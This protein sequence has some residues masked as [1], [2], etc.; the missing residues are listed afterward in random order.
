MSWWRRG[1]HLWPTSD[2]AMKIGLQLRGL[3]LATALLAIAVAWATRSAWNQLGLLEREFGT[4]HSESYH[5]AE[6]VQARM[7]ALNDVLLRLELN[8]DAAELT[9]FL[10]AGQ[11]MDSWI[12]DNKFSV[13]TRQQTGLLGQIQEALRAYLG[14]VGGVV[15]QDR[16]RKEVPGVKPLNEELDAEAKR[17]LALGE[18]LRLAEQAALAQ[19][20]THAHQSARNLKLNLG[21][22]VILIFGLGLASARL[23]YLVKIVP[24]NAKLAEARVVLE[25]REKLAALGTL[26]AGVAH[27][28]RNPL[29][30]IKIRLHSLKRVLTRESPG[31]Q[32]AAVINQEI[33]RLE[34]IVHEFLQFARPSAPKVQTIAA[35]VLFEQVNA[36]LLPQLKTAGIE[37]KI[38]SKGEVLVRADP[39]QLKQVLINL[40]QNAAESIE[41][42][43]LITLRASSG[44]VESGKI[45]V[46]ATI[47]EVEDTGKGI[48]PEVEKRLFDPFFSTK[49]VGAGLG[50]SIAAQIVEKHGGTLRYDTKLGVGTRFCIV[51][52]EITGD[53]QAGSSGKP[54]P[55]LA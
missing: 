13:S 46:P 20:M 19:L 11:E 35:G 25:R 51:L 26:A 12:K 37:L 18:Q 6:H 42:G 47:L 9:N 2:H 16:S 38:D 3:C 31:Q 7:L 54:H 17:V 40:I 32:D 30:A 27:E 50:L 1:I 53:T 5:L 52:P 48:A 49:E 34:R 44:A 41:R 15:K 36:L 14:K 8:G 4:S 28:I 43:G 33:Q 45:P 55:G 22:S 39:Q 29:T 23:I 21:L 24:L 10:L